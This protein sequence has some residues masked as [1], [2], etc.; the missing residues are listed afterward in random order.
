MVTPPVGAEAGNSGSIRTRP[1]IL[2]DGECKFCNRTVLW[3]I[4]RDTR[5]DGSD[6]RGCFDFASLQS[7]VADEVLAAERMRQPIPDGIVL[8]DG[9]RVLIKSDAA[10][11]IARRLRFPW[12]IV[13]WFG[14]VMPRTLR[15]SIYDWFA[16]NRYRWFGRSE[17]CMIPTPE[18]ETR[19]LDADERR[20]SRAVAGTTN[21]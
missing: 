6:R 13:A 19:F 11:A 9:A 20:S 3:I 16:R 1:L 14:K 2:F 7:R 17:T 8:V 5:K 15:D 18:L 10:L 12:P 21:P 4:K